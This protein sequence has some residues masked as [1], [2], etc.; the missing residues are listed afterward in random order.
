MSVLDELYV[1][2]VCKE[3]F[4]LSLPNRLAQF[5]IQT[6]QSGYMAITGSTLLLLSSN[7]AFQG[8]L[9]RSH[10]AFWSTV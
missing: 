7:T 9:V 8:D 4:L 3:K 5:A 2:V 6:L 1:L 10:I